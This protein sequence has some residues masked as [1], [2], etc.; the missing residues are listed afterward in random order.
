MIINQKVGISQ[1]EP[2][3]I[4]AAKFFKSDDLQ[5][6]L[7]YFD[8]IVRKAKRRLVICLL[9]IG[10]MTISPFFILYNYV[11][12]SDK[13]YLS[14]F[15]IFY[16]FICFL[17]NLSIHL[18]LNFGNSIFSRKIYSFDISNS[19]E[20]FFDQLKNEQVRVYPQWKKPRTDQ[21]AL[22]A[23][24]CEKGV[25]LEPPLTGEAFRSRLL[26]LLLS[27]N[28]R[29][30][31]FCIIRAW[32]SL[33]TPLYVEID[34]AQP[35][36]HLTQIERD[37]LE[38][39]QVAASEIN[40]TSTSLVPKKTPVHWRHDIP[41]EYHELFCDEFIKAA[42]WRGHKAIKVRIALMSVLTYPDYIEAERKNVESAKL[43]ADIAHSAL[44]KAVAEGKIET[45]WFADQK[46]QNP[47]GT[48]VKIFSHPG[49]GHWTEKRLKA[50]E[51]IVEIKRN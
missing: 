9:S 49:S 36:A 23:R 30:W 38:F 20:D 35:S 18:H 51:K 44:K 26:P 45:V 39:S 47:T 14:I 37:P 13:F 22:R 43:M 50:F 29:D 28:E 31:G 24:F 16:V 1:V 17:V 8:R 11:N 40:R 42:R 4:H 15:I 3:R 12:F 2:L 48:L 46:D 7:D 19:L 6:S 27:S 5:F 25:T 33:R 10:L 34:E 32:R 41:Q 21:N